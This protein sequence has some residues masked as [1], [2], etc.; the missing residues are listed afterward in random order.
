MTAAEQRAWDE[1]IH[2]LKQLGVPMPAR[3]ELAGLPIEPAEAKTEIL[4]K[5]ALDTLK[6]ANR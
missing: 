1:R 4:K 2:A 3:V 6:D 5:M